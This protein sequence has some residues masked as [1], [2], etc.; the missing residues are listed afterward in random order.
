MLSKELVLQ[1]TLRGPHS[2]LSGRRNAARAS[3]PLCVAG[4]ALCDWAGVQQI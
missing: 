3:G 1:R 2:I 4:A